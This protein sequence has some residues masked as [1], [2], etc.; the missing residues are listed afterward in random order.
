LGFPR[1]FRWLSAAFPHLIRR[2]STSVIH[3]FRPFF[4]DF[5]TSDAQHIHMF[6]Q[7]NVDK[8]F[9]QLFRVFSEAVKQ[10]RAEKN[11]G[12]SEAVSESVENLRVGLYRG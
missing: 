3:V 12:E 2:L 10:A 7:Q 1:A 11:I 4:H 6:Y 8:C 9:H 5:S